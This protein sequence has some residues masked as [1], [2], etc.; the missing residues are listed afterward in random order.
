MDPCS[1]GFFGATIASSI[2]KRKHV[3]SAFFCGFVGGLFPD[4]D[5]FVTS[6]DDPLLSIEYHRHFSH[7]IFFAPIGG[8]L[9][10]LIIKIFLRKH[11]FGRI[12]LPTTLGFLSH[13]ILDVFTSYGTSIFWP[14]SNERVSLNII[15][16]VDPIFTLILIIFCFF[17]MKTKN[18]LFA[19]IGIFFSFLYLSFG[20]FQSYKVLK[21]IT[22]IA[23]DRGHKIERVLLK[24]TIGN[25]ILWRSVYQSENLYYV[26]AVYAP[27]FSTSKIKEGSRFI[28]INKN[29]IFP[30]LEFNSKQRN[31]II[32][33]SNF[34]QG[35]IFLHP[36]Y[37][38]IIA[39]LRYGSL[40]H[41]G[42][43]LWGI[44]I[45]PDRMNNHTKFKNL[46]NFDKQMYK[47]FWEMLRGNF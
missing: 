10:T 46:R 35:F 15:S 22:E 45:D 2:A 5:I 33:F 41:D 29:T 14:L 1:Q 32:R 42:K 36:D 44:E 24:P 34:S 3:N 47:E 13:G 17:L 20:Y 27:I 43:S 23:K 26:D 40:P 28:V 6:V 21:A 25:N 19:Q 37:D 16:V 11:S 38:N 7:S 12:Y 30:E 9:T 8:F 18:I 39:D 4:F 31:D